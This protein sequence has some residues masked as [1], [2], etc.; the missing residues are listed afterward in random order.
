MKKIKRRA[1][2]I[3]LLVAVI[4]IL[5]TVFLFR[6]AGDGEDW[7]TRYP[8]ISHNVFT[9]GQLSLGTVYDRNGVILMASGD[10]PVQFHENPEVRRATMH[11]LGDRGGN[12]ATG[13]THRAAYRDLLIAY[14]FISGTYSIGGTG[15][16][17]QL[18]ID[19]E[20]SR[21]ANQALAGRPGAVVVMNYETG[22]ILV[23]VSAPNY[24]PLNRPEIRENDP[25]F[26]DVYL[27]RVFSYFY[28]P[29]SVF[30]I[31]TAA[32]ALDTYADALGRTYRCNGG[33]VVM[34]HNVRCTGNHGTIGLE[35]AMRVSCN[36]YF[37]QL[38]LDLGGNR[39]LSY[40]E[41]FGL[42]QPHHVGRIPVMAGNFEAGEPGTP[43][44]AWSG[45]G[46]GRNL[47][48]P[49]AMTRFMAAIARGGEVIEPRLL[50]CYSG[51]LIPRRYESELGERIMDAGVA[52]NLSWILRTSA[53]SAS[54]PGLDVAGK[55]GT[56]E[57]AD[58][59]PHA[60]FVGFLNDPD[61]PL[62][63]AVVVEHGGGGLAQAVP[64]AN[65]VLQAAVQG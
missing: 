30:K 54:F 44:L 25:N 4:P 64:V 23:A 46:Q 17:L 59:A 48:N 49:L 24:D 57:V 51:G 56:A 40:T 16:R 12:I 18:T 50:E 39:M 21:V 6:V 42:N 60:W 47:V 5:L 62:A 34:G 14:D 13:V 1:Y 55:T 11:V 43:D 37:A 8:S 20:L 32:A 27:S 22:E 26:T 29:G 45:A 9:R 58:G 31:V 15:G 35:E 19:A 38:A 36:P 41:Q 2:S 63:F 65:A 33:V 3:F 7:L 53:P 61:H 10:G 52:S 28:V